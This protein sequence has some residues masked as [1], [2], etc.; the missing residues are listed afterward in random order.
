MFGLYLDATEWIFY[1]YWLLFTTIRAPRNY[2]QYSYYSL[3]KA[4]RYPGHPLQTGL[5]PSHA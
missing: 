4:I 5:V 3:F 2:S 1:E